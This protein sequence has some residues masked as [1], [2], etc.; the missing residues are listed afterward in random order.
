MSVVRT[1]EEDC[2]YL[3]QI[4]R[5]YCTLDIGIVPNMRV[6]GRLYVRDGLKQMLIDELSKYHENPCGFLPALYQVGNVASL[7]GIV[8]AS[9][10]LPD[11]HSGYGFAIGNVAAFDMDDPCS[12]VSPGGVGFDINCGV[13]FIRTNLSFKDVQPLLDDL[14]RALFDSIPVGVNSSSGV[15][16]DVHEVRQVM[17]Q[18]M[19]WAVQNGYAWAEDMEHCEENGRVLAARYSSVSQRAHSRGIPQLGTL[20]AG[21]HYAEI[22][23]IEEIYDTQAAKQM[24]LEHVGQV[25][26]MIHSGSRGLGHQVATDAV[27]LMDQK[28]PEFPLNDRQLTSARIGSEEGQNYLSGMAAAANFAFVNRSVIVHQI[29]Q[30]FSKVFGMSPEDMEMDVVYDVAHNI[31]KVEEHYVDGRPKRLLVH[32]KGSTRAFGPDHPMIPLKYR[33]TGQPVLV[34]G[35]M[36]THSYVL[37]GTEKGMTETFGSTCHGAGRALARNA[38]R[39]TL[40]AED[41]L[42]SL[43]AQGISVCVASPD[44]IQEEAPSAYKDVNEVVDICHDAGISAKVVKLRPIGVIKG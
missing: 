39:K 43:K 35:S 23:V 34:G 22:Q 27:K 8:G 28:D 25:C 15:K 29:R 41:V 24:G 10:A 30:A 42:E 36:G 2:A 31:A 16:L 33:S 20:G 4:D 13:R 21:N 12:I 7:P 37:V 26:V 17:E 5:N 18:G 6:P 1:F 11:V 38:T 9:I 44:S 32:R 19:N 3:K 40:K 14:V